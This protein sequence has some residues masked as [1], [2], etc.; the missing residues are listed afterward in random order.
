M[1]EEPTG[2]S[3]TCVFGVGCGIGCLIV[4]KEILVCKKKRGGG[5]DR[6]EDIS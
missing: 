1:E 2:M 4:L 3:E 6:V 5:S